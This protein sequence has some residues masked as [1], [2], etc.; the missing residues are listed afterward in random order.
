LN[1]YANHTVIPGSALTGYPGMT[2]GVMQ[3]CFNPLLTMPGDLPPGVPFMFSSDRPEV[4][5]AV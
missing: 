3:Q 5:T 1:S 2:V 4:I